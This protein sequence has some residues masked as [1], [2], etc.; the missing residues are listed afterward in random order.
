MFVNLKKV[1]SHNLFFFALLTV[2]TVIVFYPNIL[3]DWVNW[4]DYNYIINNYLVH[5]FSFNRILEIFKTPQ[6]MGNYHPVTLLSY[7]LEYEF[8]GPNAK[9]F[10]ITNII[11]HTVNSVL[12]FVFIEKLFGNKAWSFSVALL[13]VIH[14]MH[15]ESVAWISARKDLLFTMFM[16]LGLILYFNYINKKTWYSY[17]FIFTFFVLSLLSKGMAIIFPAL[18]V[19]T[20]YLK[21]TISKRNIYE[22]IPFFVVA[23][24][25]L[26]I[27]IKAQRTEG[28]M[29]PVSESFTL[30]NIFISTY[31]LFIYIVKFFVPYHISAFHPY[32]GLDP[33][34]IP[35]YFYYSVILIPVLLYI[36]VRSYKKIP[37]VFFGLSFF[38][39][40][41]APVIQFFPFGKALYAERYT[42]VSYIGLSII[43]VYG[44]YWLN[45]N[46]QQK[47]TVFKPILSQ[48]VVFWL[49]VLVYITFSSAKYW[50]NSDTL[51]TNVIEKYPSHY[52]AYGNRANDEPDPNK[53]IRDYTTC[54]ELNPG[55][56]EAYNNRG[57]KYYQLHEMDKAEQDFTKTLEINP[58]YTKAYINLGMLYT[59]NGKNQ[60]ALQAFNTVIQSSSANELAYFNRGA[61]FFKMNNMNEALDDFN[62]AIEINPN[63]YQ[64]YE[65]RGRTFIVLNKNNLAKKDFETALSLNP[66]SQKTKEYLKAY[67]N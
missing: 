43:L 37:I 59:Y 15:L 50:K 9:V 1:L 38:L 56:Y 44:F 28:A 45:S 20:D 24:I 6:V 21:G 26:W 41:I 8:A 4:D 31:G 60:A 62:R 25:F 22:K 2:N 61:L 67:F 30:N 29:L 42:Y 13:F 11:L 46:L 36:M 53:A 12:L 49:I 5:G 65:E 51:W 7:A 54:V 52:F 64:F 57:L 16:F 33:K 3:N 14:P 35:G 34:V 58:D 10:H 23:I 63:V 47:W 39:V 19:L 55:F 40:S 32:P 66:D 48:V 27:G 17:L 18:L